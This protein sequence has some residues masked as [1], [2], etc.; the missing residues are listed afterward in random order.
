MV[1]DEKVHAFIN[2]VDPPMGMYLYGRK[3]YETMA[4]W[5]TP[6]VVP[7]RT[8]AMLDFAR[9]RQAAD[10]IVYSKSLE[11]VSTRKTRLEREFDPQVIR[12]LKVQLPHDVAVG[13]S[14]PRRS[15]DSG[16]APRRV[17]SVRRAYLHWRW[18]AIPAR[19]R[20]RDAGT[21]GRALF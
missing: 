11:T 19:Q 18:Q 17:S 14:Q 2:D 15:R 21:S 12:D 4:G 16:Q 13:W 5:E 20:P 9:I 8:P 6:D 1:P 3:M 7:Y 10:K